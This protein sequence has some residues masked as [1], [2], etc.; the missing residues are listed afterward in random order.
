MVSCTLFG[1]S[2]EKKVLIASLVS[3]FDIHTRFKFSPLFVQGCS[4]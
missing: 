2:V 4:R 1:G 3:I